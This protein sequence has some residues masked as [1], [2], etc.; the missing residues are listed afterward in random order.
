VHDARL[1]RGLGED[2][3]DRFGESFEAVDAVGH[4]RDQ[5]R[6]DDQEEDK[7]RRQKKREEK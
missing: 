1:H 7:K 5:P 3:F 6:Q 2:R 4:S